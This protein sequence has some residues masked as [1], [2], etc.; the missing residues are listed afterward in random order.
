MCPLLVAGVSTVIVGGTTDLATDIT[1]SAGGFYFRSL[2][3]WSEPLSVCQAQVATALV[4]RATRI[5]AC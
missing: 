5:H 3:L 4:S 1:S 2:S